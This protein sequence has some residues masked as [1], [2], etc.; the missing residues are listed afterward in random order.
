MHFIGLD[1]GSVAVKLV[2]LDKNGVVIERHY[3]RHYGHAVRTAL[4]LLKVIKEKFSESSLSITG[5]A[6]KIIAS[7][8]K[9]SP[10]NEIVSQFY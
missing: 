8:L 10:I 2:V 1:A 4:E 6:G 3:V 5:S 7:T 9:I